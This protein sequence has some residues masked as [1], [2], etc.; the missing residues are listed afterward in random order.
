MGDQEAFEPRPGRHCEDCPFQTLCPIYKHK[1][2]ENES[3]T[4]A[5]VGELT[6]RELIDEVYMLGQ[7]SKEI[8]AKKSLYIELLKKYAEDNGYTHRLW[9]T[10][11]K[12]TLSK[13]D[14][15]LAIKEAKDMLIEKLKTKGV[16]ELVG[17]EEIDKKA[18]DELFYSQKLSAGEFE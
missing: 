10:A 16:W 18:L 14:E 12:L 8:E 1:F 3:I 6:I 4:L 2:A 5:D 15:Y 11:A 13:K 17:K 7:Q 9:G